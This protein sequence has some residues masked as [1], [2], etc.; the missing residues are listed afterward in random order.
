MTK[1]LVLG[2]ERE[3]ALSLSLPFFTLT[4]AFGYRSPGRSQ[5]TEVPLS[6]QSLTMRAKV[7]TRSPKLKAKMV[8]AQ[9]T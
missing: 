1:K 2:W 4:Y 6:S 3:R 7:R 5:D 8:R 9:S